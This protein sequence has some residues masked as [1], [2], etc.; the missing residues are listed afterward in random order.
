MYDNNWTTRRKNSYILNALL[1]GI[2]E[3]NIKNNRKIFKCRKKT[4][5]YEIWR[6]LQLSLFS[7]LY[8]DGYQMFI[9]HYVLYVINKL[10]NKIDFLHCYWTQIMLRTHE[11]NFVFRK[12]NPI[13]DF[14][15]SNQMPYTDQ[16]TLIALYVRSHFW[17]T[18]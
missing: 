10:C 6:I 12:K 15:R 5:N 8:K 17:V 9:K 14:S 18:I 4:L 1:Y 13:F 7:Y 11:G 2:L 16:I 3:Q